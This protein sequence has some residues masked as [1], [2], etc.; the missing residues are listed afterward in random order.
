MSGLPNIMGM[1]GIG[2]KVMVSLPQGT[3]IVSVPEGLSKMGKGQH[4]FQKQYF[5]KDI[6]RLSREITS[7]QE[8][9]IAALLISSHYIGRC[10]SFCIIH[11]RPEHAELQEGDISLGKDIRRFEKADLGIGLENGFV[12]NV[13]ASGKATYVPDT[14]FEKHKGVFQLPADAGRFIRFDMPVKMDEVTDVQRKG[15]D[16]SALRDRIAPHSRSLFLM[17]IFMNRTLIG[18]LAVGYEA[19]SRFPLDNPFGQR[20]IECLWEIGDSVGS[21]LQKMLYPRKKEE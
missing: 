6:K 12:A 13:I 15:W 7:L 20:D 14:R 8:L 10:S 3:F 18:I 1:L 9:D 11:Q 2:G 19:D 21:A 17:P 5:D 16:V 4:S